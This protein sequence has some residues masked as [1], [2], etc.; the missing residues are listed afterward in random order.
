MSWRPII[1]YSPRASGEFGAWMIVKIMARRMENWMLS[2][3]L[4]GLN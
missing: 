3:A 1:D 2:R 4:N